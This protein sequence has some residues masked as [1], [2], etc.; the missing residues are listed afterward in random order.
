MKGG[1]FFLVVHPITVVMNLDMTKLLGFLLPTLDV[2]YRKK[3]R[4]SFGV[5]YIM[6][7]WIQGQNPNISLPIITFSPPHAVH[8]CA[9][10]AIVLNGKSHIT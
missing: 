8:T 7:L 4:H 1:A 5:Y 9:L 10:L 6:E 3:T 2:D